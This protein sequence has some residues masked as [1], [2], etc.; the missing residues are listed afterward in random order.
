MED[1]GAGADRDRTL[2]ALQRMRC[3]SEEIAHLLDGR[4][5]SIAKGI[6]DVLEDAGFTAERD[7]GTERLFFRDAAGNFAGTW[8]LAIVHAVERERALLDDLDHQRRDET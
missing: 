3:E 2:E 1:E 4:E 8:L 5:T 7:P 6:S